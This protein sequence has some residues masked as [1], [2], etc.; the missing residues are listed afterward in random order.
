ML[1]HLDTYQS[2][3]SPICKNISKEMSASWKENNPVPKSDLRVIKVLHFGYD[4]QI[5]D[6]IL[7]MH[8][9]VAEE[10]TQIFKELFEA[11]YPIEK[12]L[13]VDAYDADDEKSCSDNN[14][15]AFCS[16]PIT[17][18]PHEWSFHSYGVAIDINPKYNPYHKNGN[19]VPKN[20]EAFLDRSIDQKGL[21]THDDLCF[22]IFSKY[23]WQWGGDWQESR[24]YVDYQH[25]YKPIPEDISSLA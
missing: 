24:G 9:S 1:L 20:G 25:F 21:I 15:S 12:M 4:D 5:H 17:G 7:I 14:S 18:K 3:I 22:Q 8:K 13:L 23:G 10:I 6:G 19:T 11:R 2:S 16:R